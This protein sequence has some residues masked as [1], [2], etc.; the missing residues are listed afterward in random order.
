VGGRGAFSTQSIARFVLVGFATALL[1]APAAQAA[2]SIIAGSVDAASASLWPLYIAEKNGY[3]DAAEVKPEIIFS[4]SNASVIQQL[5]AG[6]LNI[7]PSAGLVDPIRAIDKGASLAIVRILIQA[8]PYALLAKPAVKRTADL[9]GKTIIIGGPKDI[10][11][12]F[13]ERMLTASGLKPGD[14]DFVFAGATSARFS[15]LQSGAVDAAIL[16]VPFNFYAETAGF[17]NLGFTF[18]VVPDMP[19]AGMA[20]NRAWAAA[21]PKIIERFLTAVGKGIGWFDDPSHREE[22]VSLM[23]ARSKTKQQ[24][25]ERSYDFLRMHNLFEPTGKVSR[26]KIGTVVEAL[27]QLGDVPAGFSLDRLFLPGVT[28]VTD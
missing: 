8:P 19:F 22:A 4:Q 20:V 15:A 28:Q 24:D 27:Q 3:F 21:N 13:T 16:T 12:I 7:A 6:S 14:Y 18:E 1:L 23:V 11:R 2:E 9:K 5:T 17:T 25:V 26:K 10:T